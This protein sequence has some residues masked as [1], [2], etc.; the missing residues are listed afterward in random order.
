M[1]VVCR[2]VFLF[3]MKTTASHYDLVMLL[4]V[5]VAAR[6]RVLFKI[7]VPLPRGGVGSLLLLRSSGG[8][9]IAFRMPSPRW[10]DSG[11]VSASICGLV[12]S[13]KLSA[14]VWR[15]RLLLLFLQVNSF[16][17][18]IEFAVQVRQHVDQLLT[19]ILSSSCA[20]RQWCP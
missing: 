13:G 1:R 3:T 14:I 18:H 7:R 20:S 9:S 10:R 2:P 12:T 11:R 5:T 6:R 16:C 17:K 4:M 15:G 8:D 19:R